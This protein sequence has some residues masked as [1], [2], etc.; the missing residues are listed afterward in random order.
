MYPSVHSDRN[1]HLKVLIFFE[2]N[3]PDF[4]IVQTDPDDLKK[5]NYGCDQVFTQAEISI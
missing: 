2:K 4:K 3:G 1:K 5:H